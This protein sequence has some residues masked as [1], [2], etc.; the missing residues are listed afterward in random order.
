ME[1]NEYKKK[2]LTVADETLGDLQPVAKNIGEKLGN[3]IK[4]EFVNGIEKILSKG[5]NKIQSKIKKPEGNK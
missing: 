4:E 3:L 5:R 1:K 2:F